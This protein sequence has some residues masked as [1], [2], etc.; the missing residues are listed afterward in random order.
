M[1][2]RRTS[3]KSDTR[4][5][6]SS[7]IYIQR[8]FT[9]GGRAGRCRAGER[10]DFQGLLSSKCS[11]LWVLLL[12]VHCGNFQRGGNRESP[13]AERTRRNLVGKPLPQHE[14]LKMIGNAAN[15]RLE[16]REVCKSG[17]ITLRIA[18]FEKWITGTHGGRVAG[19]R[20]KRIGG[21]V[22]R[23]RIVRPFRE[24]MIPNKSGASRVGWETGPFAV[25][26]RCPR[27]AVT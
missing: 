26:P 25:R 10:A 17:T 20:I 2:F 9:A 19:G 22:V 4:A 13:A 6:R 15:G 3:A 8:R 5:P 27:L 24:L 23:E 12:T 21:R 18:D 7:S 14:L 1:D 16:G 11:R